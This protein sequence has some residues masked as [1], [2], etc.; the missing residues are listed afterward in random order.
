MSKTDMLLQS[1]TRK[2]TGKRI[3]GG[4][5]TL[6]SAAIFAVYAAGYE[7]TKAAAD[8]FEQQSAERLASFPIPVVSEETAASTKSDSSLLNQLPNTIS[9]G[10]RPAIAVSTKDAVAVRLEVEPPL[11][12]SNSADNSNA[13][14][15]STP[16]D[17]TEI[18][19]SKPIEVTP[20]LE[21]VAAVSAPRAI[22][23]PAPAPAPVPVPAPPPPAVRQSLYKDGT[24]E[25][26]G[27]SRHG[28][29]GVS[30]VIQDGRIASAVIAQ[31]R[32]RYPCSWIS[33][34]PGQVV[35]RQ[36]PN[37]DYVSGATQSVNAYY[38]AVVEALSRAK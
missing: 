1:I 35:S 5:I 31:C 14:S 33:Q 12:A 19:S 34:L 9:P 18:P 37:V 30:V 29:I 3:S 38:T 28:D 27:T 7:Q 11:V 26:W 32:T 17:A 25:G 20:I 15:A 22:E 36:S 6:S 10:V 13:A 23:P 4:L 24:Y 21:P 16:A 2:L 8:R